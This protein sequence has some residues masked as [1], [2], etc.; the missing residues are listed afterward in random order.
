MI[1]L[2]SDYKRPNKKLSF[3]S[4]DFWQIIGSYN[5]YWFHLVSQNEGKNIVLAKCS[6][7]IEYNQARIDDVFVPSIYRGNRYAYL[8]LKQV[9]EILKRYDMNEDIIYPI[10]VK[11]RFRLESI[12][13]F[14]IVGNIPANKTYEKL[15]DRGEKEDDEIIFYSLYITN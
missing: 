8:L 4:L 5:D 2:I 1:V 7:A 9:I 3:F 12:Y 6:V 15:F 11:P 13:L 10:D 14:A